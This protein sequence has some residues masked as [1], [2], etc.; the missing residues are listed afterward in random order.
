MNLG[1][2]LILIFYIWPCSTTAIFAASLP[3]S[4]NSAENEI[5][6]NQ[7]LEISKRPSWLHGRGLDGDGNYLIFSFSF[8]G[9][10][11]INNTPNKT[12]P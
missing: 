12:P 3:S 9:K 1:C 10:F 5:L 6:E 2:A 4:D 8:P 11:P 7:N